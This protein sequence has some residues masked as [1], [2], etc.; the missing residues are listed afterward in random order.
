MTM[1]VDMRAGHPF[2]RDFDHWQATPGRELVLS[3]DESE[4][5]I[6]HSLSRVG[7]GGPDVRIERLLLLTV[8][9]FEEGAGTDSPVTLQIGGP[10][11]LVVDYDLPDTPQFDLEANTVN[12]YFVPVVV[13]FTKRELGERS[14]RLSIDGDDLWRPNQIYLFGLDRSRGRPHQVVPLVNSGPEVFLSTDP[15]E[16]AA[17]VLLPLAR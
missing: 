9:G 16:G 8:T 14:I 10:D 17:S 2:R 12:W 4:G 3:T 15:T 1:D 11:E 6:S 7:L 5:D 13:P